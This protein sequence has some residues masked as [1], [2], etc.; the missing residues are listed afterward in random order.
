M[1]GGHLEIKM[2]PVRV[3]VNDLMQKGY[4]YLRT[5]PAG[6]N[7][8][9]GFQPQLTPRQMLELGVFGGKYMTDCAAEFP[10]GRSGSGASASSTPSSAP[11]TTTP[12]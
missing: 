1:F 3:E 12:S 5:E 8:Q 11:T 9:P 10:P 2:K 6:R 4:V 7:F